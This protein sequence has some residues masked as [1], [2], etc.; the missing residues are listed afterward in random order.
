VIALAATAGSNTAGAR[1]NTTAWV[2]PRLGQPGKVSLASL[3]GKPVVVNFFAS[4]CTECQ[5][6]LPVFANE[7]RQLRGKV[8]FVEVNSLE[9]G[10]GLGMAEQFHLA[11]AGAIVASDVGGAQSSGL[12]DA[13]G[14]GSSMP[15]TAFYDSRGHLLTTHLGALDSASLPSTLAQLYGSAV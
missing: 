12:H 10:N 3:R 1:T 13:L 4:W 14:G 2:L 11:G 8:A 6:E 5:A 7:T 15:L 9:T